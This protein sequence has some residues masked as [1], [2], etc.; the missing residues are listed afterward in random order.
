MLSVWLAAV[1]VGLLAFVVYCVTA[2]PAA[3]WPVMGLVFLPNR[4]WLLLM[5]WSVPVDN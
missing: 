4:M 5:A 3:A 2:N 1:A